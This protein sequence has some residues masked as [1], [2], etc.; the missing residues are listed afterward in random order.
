MSTLKDLR[1]AFPK[2]FIPLPFWIC[3]GETMTWKCPRCGREFSRQNQDHYCVRPQNVD[4][5]IAAQDE[6]YRPRLEEIR[7]IL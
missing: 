3:R 1:A 6:N 7:V 4:E 5:Y 2:V